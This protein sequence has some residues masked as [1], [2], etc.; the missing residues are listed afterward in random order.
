METKT[1]PQNK[2]IL[3]YLQ[4]GKKITWM[5]ALYLFGSSRLSA[6][7]FDLHKLGYDIDGDMIEITS[8]AVYS[9]K[10]RV[11]QYFIKKEKA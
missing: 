11:K 2:R 1:E 3:A 7:I 5:D 8:P 10:K 9:G 4:Q 6:R